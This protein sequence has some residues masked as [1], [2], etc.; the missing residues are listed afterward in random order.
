MELHRMYDIQE[1]NENLNKITRWKFS[2]I[3]KVYEHDGEKYIELE[4]DKMLDHIRKNE[5]IY[6]SPKWSRKGIIILTGI[7]SL[8]LLFVILFYEFIL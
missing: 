2:Q 7:I 8:Y 3:N 6:I 5:K 4:K 1:I